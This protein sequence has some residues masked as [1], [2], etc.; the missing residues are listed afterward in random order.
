MQV[1]VGTSL[2]RVVK[3]R[4]MRGGSRGGKPG[5]SFR[6]QQKVR[7]LQCI[8]PC[9]SILPS[10]CRCTDPP[11]DTPN[12]AMIRFAQ[13]AVACILVDELELM[14]LA[15]DLVSCGIRTIRGHKEGLIVEFRTPDER[16][17]QGVP[18][19]NLPHLL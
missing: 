14:H 15:S 6:R 8:G 11:G 18:G 2:R 13:A 7:Y 16:P 17:L 19:Y 12:G 4:G 5:F 9:T 10:P 1:G 3:L